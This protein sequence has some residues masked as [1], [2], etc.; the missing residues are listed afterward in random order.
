MAIMPKV[1][2]FFHGKIVIFLVRPIQHDQKG[3]GFIS[4]AGFNLR[5]HCKFWSSWSYWFAKM[6][7]WIFCMVHTQMFFLYYFSILKAIFIIFFLAWYFPSDVDSTMKAVVES[8]SSGRC[9]EFRLFAS[10][11]FALYIMSV[12]IVTDRLLYQRCFSLL[13][14][15]L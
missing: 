15:M 1:E 5:D 6:P 13:D 9:Y 7:R 10:C 11:T 8:C 14:S 2:I 12:A 3:C 4:S